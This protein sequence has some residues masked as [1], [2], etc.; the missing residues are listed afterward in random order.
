MIELTYY[1]HSAFLLSNGDQN[2]LF[3]PWFS[4]NPLASIAAS[5][6]PKI[7][8]ILVSHGHADHLGDAVE[9]SKQHRVAIIAPF[10]LAMFCQRRGAQVF[11]MNHGG[12]A[13]FDF[14]TVR[15]TRAIHSSAYVDK[16]A[17]Y[18]GNPCGFVVDT[19]GKTLY[20]A[21][22][23]A[24][25]SDMKLI[26]ERDDIDIALVPI[27]DVFTMG[28]EDAGVAVDL[29]NADFAVPMHYATF[30]VLDQTP[31]KFVDEMASRAAEA[32]VIEIGKSH[33]FD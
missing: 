9:I 21:G 31:Q 17:E 13:T 10:E 23:T 12:R 27:G 30:E 3:D 2:I 18:T 11:P 26:G 28:A 4:G 16:G 32:V 6:L 19:G 25:F 33:R 24:L 14:G 1:G 20:Y 29:L 22:D 7:D 8:A 5:E 15:M